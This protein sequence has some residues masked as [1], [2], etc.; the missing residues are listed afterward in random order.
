MINRQFELTRDDGSPDGESMSKISNQVSLGFLLLHI[1]LGFVLQSSPIFAT[2]HAV[3][4][5]ILGLFYLITD[6]NP[7][8]L[9]YL[10]GYIIGAELLWRGT[11][12]SIF[13]ETAK[14]AITLF[15][16]LG[17]MNYRK[18]IK[19]NIT[20]LIYFILLLPSIAVMPGFDREGIAFSLAGPMALAFAA[21][22]LNSVSIDRA[23]V[24][25]LLLAILAP[26]ISW[27]ILVAVGILSADEIVLS[28]SKE[29]S[30]SGGIGPNQVSSVLGLGALVAFLFVV[31]ENKRKFLRFVVGVIMIWLIVQTVLTF[32]RGGLWTTVGAIL[33]SSIF[34]IREKKSRTRYFF[35]L[36]LI[37][38]FSLIVFPAL[39]DYAGGAISERFSDVGTTGRIE[40][41]RSDWEVFKRFPLFGVGPFQSKPYH[42]LF[43]RFSSTHTEYSRMLAEH[44]TLGLISLI[45]LIGMIITRLFVKT[46]PQGK[47]LIV[48]FLTWGLLFMSHSA[49]RLAAPSFLIALSFLDFSHDEFI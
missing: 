42:A 20:P 47:G 43:F 45:I 48:A 40:I 29:F 31:I 11:H 27:G 2:L 24:K 34:F 49:T 39:D 46:S 32:S 41:I 17:T 28:M 23:Q 38:S 18:K 3:T 35:F 9:I 15:A 1:P 33:T 8:H 44:G 19:L 5:L 10:L 4:V 7:Y 13:W 30:T 16:L 6:K 26:I 14:Y 12:A 22:F 37:I 36:I 25:N 21:M